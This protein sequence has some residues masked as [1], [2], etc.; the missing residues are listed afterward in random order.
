[1]S[2]KMMTKI[3]SNSKETSQP[4]LIFHLIAWG[5]LLRRPTVIKYLISN[6]QD[7]LGH[8]VEMAQTQTAP[9]RRFADSTA[10]GGAA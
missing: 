9:I 10:I 8:K 3:Y 5:L 7:L 4:L 2:N 6:I 1:M